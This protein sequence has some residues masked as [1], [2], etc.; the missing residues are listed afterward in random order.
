LECAAGELGPIVSNDTIQDP[1]PADDGLEKLNYGLLVY[2]DHR[3]RFRSF[4]EFVYG[5]IE[6][7]VAS[8]SQGKWPQ[9]VQPPNNE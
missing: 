6:I 4:G 3:G 1:K 2:L 7:P 5:N 8:D 9:D